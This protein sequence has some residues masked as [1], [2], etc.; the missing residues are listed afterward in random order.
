[1]FQ[2]L[3]DRVEL[4]SSVGLSDEISLFGQQMTI[5]VTI[6]SSSLKRCA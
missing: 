2:F 1:M 5:T 4:S 3:G 6:T